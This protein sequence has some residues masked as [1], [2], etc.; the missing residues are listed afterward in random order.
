MTALALFLSLAIVAAPPAS[1]QTLTTLYNF[2]GG[3]DGA[4]PMSGLI[5]WGGNLYGTAGFGGIQGSNCTT[6]VAYGPGCGTVFVLDAS[7]KH[8][9]VYTF[10]GG[11]DAAR[12]QGRPPGLEVEPAGTHTQNIAR[13]GH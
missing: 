5:A 12:P 8:R 9:V 1:A 2:T 4:A 7:G 3:A 10:K 13:P 11:S 6:N